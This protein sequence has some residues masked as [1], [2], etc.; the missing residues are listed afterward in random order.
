MQ[1]NIPRTWIPDKS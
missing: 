1:I